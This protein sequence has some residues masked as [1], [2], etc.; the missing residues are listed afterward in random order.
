MPR[1]TVA[2]GAFLYCSLAL[3][4]DGFAFDSSLSFIGFGEG[5]R[6]CMEYLAARQ[7]ESAA[8]AL[9]GGGENLQ[10]TMSYAA[11]YAFVEGWVT[12]ADLFWPDTYNLFPG[13]LEPAMLW[14]ENHCRENPAQKLTSALL[15]LWLDALP[16]RQQLA[17]SYADR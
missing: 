15:I 3:A 13:G 5:N 1:K 6:S 10:Y 8:R 11:M 2:I 12:A 16:N 7:A 14:L 17:P 4:I 9:R